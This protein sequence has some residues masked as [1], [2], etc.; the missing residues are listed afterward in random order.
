MPIRKIFVEMLEFGETTKNRKFSV[1]NLTK[2]FR[3][4]AGSDDIK[5]ITK[6]DANVDRN[7]VVI[8]GLY[9]PH[10]DESNY[11][12]IAIYVNYNPRQ[13]VILI[14]DTDWRQIC[15]DLI[16]CVGHEIVHQEQYRSREFDIGPHIFVSAKEERSHRE[17]QEYLG[18][19][20]EIEA[21]GYSIAAEIYLKENPTKITGRNVVK[22]TMY[23]AYCKAFD[24]NHPIVKQLLVNTLK[25]YTKLKAGGNS[26]VKK[27]EQCR[28]N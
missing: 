16:E 10:E 8:G 26:Y 20:D 9:D 7:Q 15:V 13:K 27:S 25:Y 11:S 19:P 21:Y 6:R 24:P 12:S 3:R 5:L 22:T 18:N 2:I 17:E 1:P 28:N 14:R 23:K 4:Y